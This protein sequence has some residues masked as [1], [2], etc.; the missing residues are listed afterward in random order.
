MKRKLI[1]ENLDLDLLIEQNPPAIPG[2]K[3]EILVEF[4]SLLYEIP[5]KRKKLDYKDGYVPL[6]SPI[7]KRISRNYKLYM[8]YLIDTGILESDNLY[9]FKRSKHYRFTGKYTQKAKRIVTERKEYGKKKYLKKS[10]HSRR[11]SSIEKHKYAYLTKPFD[12]LTIDLDLA[13]EAVEKNYDFKMSA[14]KVLSEK[15]RQELEHERNSNL[16]LIHSIE[17][18]TFE[19]FLDK[20]INRFHSPITFMPKYLRHF[21]TYNGESLSCSDI[22]NCHPFLS[23]VL[24]NQNFWHPCTDSMPSKLYTIDKLQ[25]FELQQRIYLFILSFITM[26]LT[27]VDNQTKKEFLTYTRAACSGQFYDVLKDQLFLDFGM[28]KEREEI[29]S[30][31]FASI[32][33]RTGSK[34]ALIAPFKTLYPRVWELFTIL[35]MLEHSHLS[36]LVMN[37]ESDIMLNHVSKRLAEEHNIEVI[38]TVHDSIITLEKDTGIVKKVMCDTLNEFIGHRPSVGVELLTPAN[39]KFKD[40]SYFIP[41]TIAA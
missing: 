23:T 39:C 33:S 12:N 30:M 20:S 24:F 41:H 6:Y 13:T 15:K 21:L 5:S 8:T 1:P 26:F 9:Y 32:Y 4:I 28:E 3:K 38:Y 25:C 36:I 14:Y 19:Y 35:K 29:K 27:L 37:I 22:C 7:L 31:Y 2:F 16:S 17:N 18:K 10:N 11:L 40:G 34:A